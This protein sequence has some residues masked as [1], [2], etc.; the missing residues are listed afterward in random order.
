VGGLKNDGDGGANVHFAFQQDAG[1]VDAGNVRDNS[2]P[3]TGAAGDLA[4]AHN[5]PGRSVRTRWT[6]TSLGIPRPLSG[7]VRVQWPSRALEVM[8]WT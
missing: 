6:A 4:P 8:S 3:Q 5:P 2:Q 7:T 1:V